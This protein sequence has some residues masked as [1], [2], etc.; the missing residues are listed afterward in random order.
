MVKEFANA[1]VALP[2]TKAVSGVVE[3]E[4]GYHIIKV[5]MPTDDELKAD[6]VFMSEVSNHYT[7]SNIVALKEKADELGFEIKDEKLNDL[8][9]QYIEQAASEIAAEVDTPVEETSE[10]NE[11]EDGE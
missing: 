11:S 10:E 1:A 7:Y 8:I 5:E 6:N 3:T 2:D 9:N 4:F